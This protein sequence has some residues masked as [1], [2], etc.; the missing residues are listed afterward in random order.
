MN[1]LKNLLVVLGVVSV[2]TLATTTA[3]ARTAPAPDAK[4]APGASARAPGGA[5]WGADEVLRAQ[6]SLGAGPLLGATASSEP[7]G[8]LASA[9]CHPTTTDPCGHAAPPPPPAAP[10]A[11]PAAEP[12]PRYPRKGLMM[13][14]W[15]ML[16]VNWIISTIVGAAILDFESAGMCE[17]GCKRLGYLLMVPV[18]GPWIAFIDAEDSHS[19]R[20]ALL[21]LALPQLAGAIMAIIGTVQ[22][23]S[24]KA[25]IAASRGH[26]GISIGSGWRMTAGVSSDGQGPAGGVS[27]STLL[28]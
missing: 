28:Q 6:L 9:G 17:N 3:R 12:A 1:T 4:L 26:S 19:S 21:T 7:E 15:I 18:A 22:H 24:D 27:F 10:A 11:G 13:T 8:W 14:G 25:E 5:G 2:A 20:T 23:V 16:G